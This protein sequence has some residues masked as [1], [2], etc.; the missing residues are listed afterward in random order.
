MTGTFVM[1]TFMLSF[2]FGLFVLTFVLCAVALAR[3]WHRK[4]GGD[5]GQW[6]SVRKI[7]ARRD[8]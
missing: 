8:D 5:D 6:S 1:G 4:N 3:Y 2:F 7:M